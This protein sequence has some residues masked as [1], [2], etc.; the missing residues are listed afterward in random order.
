MAV[1]EILLDPNR[2]FRQIQRQFQRNVHT[3]LPGRSYPAYRTPFEKW[4]CLSPLLI[5][6]DSVKTYGA[7]TRYS[8]ILNR[9]NRWIWLISRCSFAPGCNLRCL[10]CRRLEGSRDDLSASGNRTPSVFSSPSLRIYIGWAIVSPQSNEF[11]FLAF[12]CFGS[13][14]YGRGVF[15]AV[16][17]HAIVTSVNW[18]GSNYTLPKLQTLALL[19]GAT[20]FI[21][22]WL[23]LYFCTFIK[24]ISTV[25]TVVCGANQGRSCVSDIT[26]NREGRLE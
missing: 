16:T 26:F 8:S 6:H 5:K 17:F 1:P 25:F 3:L 14:P 22:F 15:S 9:T 21:N 12:D 2:T 24:S 7:C 11:L 13:V 19:F 23:R 10:S 4:F 20:I 18:G